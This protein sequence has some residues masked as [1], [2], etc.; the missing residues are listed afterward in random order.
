MPES[1]KHGPLAPGRPWRSIRAA[2]WTIGLIRGLFDWIGRHE[3]SVLLAMTGAALAVLAFVRIADAVGE[4]QTLKFDEWAVRAMRRVDDSAQPI[5]PPWL[6][7]VTRD[8]TALG[9]VAVLSLLVIA[10]LG[11]LWLK[12]MVGAMWLVVAAT[13]G[14]LIVSTVLKQGFERPRPDIVPHLS[15][16]YTSSFPSGHSLLSATVFL[17]LGALLG[18]FVQEFRLKAYFL[19][20]AVTL[21]FLVGLSRVYL[22]V[23]WPTDVLAGWCAGLAWATLC[24]LVARSLQHRGTVE[25]NTD[26]R[27]QPSTAPPW[28]G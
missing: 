27:D 26:P 21:T 8:V 4:G 28:A 6:A 18:R 19:I 23:H 14:G 13:L 11:F 5:G 22:G 15:P 9:G 16:T 25:Q 20:V 2:T 7:E 1:E 10:V 24:W 3:L 12:R 17:T